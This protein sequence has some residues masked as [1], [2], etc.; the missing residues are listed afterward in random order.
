[1][2]RADGLA[3]VTQVWGPGEVVLMVKPQISEEGKRQ[4]WD[5]GAPRK[6]TKTELCSLGRD[7]KVARR[8]PSSFKS[9]PPLPLG[10]LVHLDSDPISASGSPSFGLF[11]AKKTILLAKDVMFLESLNY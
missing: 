6:F 4:R 11:S 7:P 5:G 2:G 10:R 3:W 8:P 9:F 1:M